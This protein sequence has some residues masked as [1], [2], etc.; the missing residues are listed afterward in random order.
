MK[1]KKV[2][3]SNRVASDDGLERITADPKRGDKVRNRKADPQTR[4]V[5]DRTLG[6]GVH[7]CWNAQI[8][9]FGMCSLAD[10]KKFC[11]GAKVLERSN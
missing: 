6:G 11:A 3:R 2:Q 4:L 8:G 9:Y 7:Y 1:A 10:W 5:T